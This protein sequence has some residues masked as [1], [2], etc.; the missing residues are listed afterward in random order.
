[1]LFFCIV[2][3]CL[4]GD[5]CFLEIIVTA[6][7]MWGLCR[8]RQNINRNFELRW[9]FFLSYPSFFPSI[10]FHGWH[11][12][13]LLPTGTRSLQ[14]HYPPLTNRAVYATP[15][16]LYIACV[17]L[18][19]LSSISSPSTVI[20]QLWIYFLLQ[21]CS[22]GTC[23]ESLCAADSQSCTV[24]LAEIMTVCFFCSQII[25]FVAS[26]LKGRGLVLTGQQLI[27]AT[28][29]LYGITCKHAW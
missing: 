21:C 22:V 6:D 11:A 5:T 19:H 3:S 26:S 14:S 25:L 20:A 12:E 18:P 13:P 29:T 24:L 16:K 7:V 4:I 10:Y 8:R 17:S 28:K 27:P 23:W 15:I 9:S 2:G 1:M